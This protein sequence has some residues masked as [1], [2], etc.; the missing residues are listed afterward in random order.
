MVAGL[1]GCVNTAFR[2]MAECHKRRQ[3]ED[4]ALNLSMGVWPSGGGAHAA[5]LRSLR[6]FFDRELDGLPF[7]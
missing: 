1:I 6:C 7:L 4:D 3:A 5:G 2:R